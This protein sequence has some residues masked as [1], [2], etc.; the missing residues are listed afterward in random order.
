[1]PSSVF[2]QGK[3]EVVSVLVV[4]SVGT[5]WGAVDGASV[6][7]REMSEEVH[8]DQVHQ[9]PGGQRVGAAVGGLKGELGRRLA[10]ERRSDAPVAL[11]SFQNKGGLL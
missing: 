7:A 11:R 10:D 6:L 5:S 9:R 1:M 2:A 8:R 3:D 4:C